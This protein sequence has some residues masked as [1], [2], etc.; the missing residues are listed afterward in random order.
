MIGLIAL[1][2]CVLLTVFAYRDGSDAQTEAG[3]L[4]LVASA[5]FPI[6]GVIIYFVQRN[7]VCDPNKYLKW[8]LCGFIVGLI[9]NIVVGV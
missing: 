1:I 8:A 5:L 6:I 7:K 4:G 9:F 2:I 3:K